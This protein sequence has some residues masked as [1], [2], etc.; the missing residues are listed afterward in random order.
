MIQDVTIEIGPEMR[1]AALFEWHDGA[2]SGSDILVDLMT[3]LHIVRQGYIK[4]TLFAN[5]YVTLN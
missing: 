5:R 1:T 4:P 2:P 3:A